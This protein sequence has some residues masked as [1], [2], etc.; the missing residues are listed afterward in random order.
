MQKNQPQLLKGFRDFLPEE[1][2]Q[3]DY[4]EKKIVG[5]FERFGFDPIETPALEYRETIMG[6]YGEEAD[7][8]VYSFKDRGERDVAL[9]Y[10]QTVPTAR[11]I[12]N[13]RDRLPFPFRRYQV[14]NVFRADKP[15]KGR[16]REFTQ[17]DIDIFGSTEPIA[18]AEVLAC[19]YFAYKNV[20]FSNV[21]LRV[22]DRRLLMATLE[23]FATDQVSVFSIIQS[24]DKL[25]KMSRDDVRG[26]LE[27]KGLGKD[28]ALEC[29]SAMDEAVVPPELQEILRLT[30]TL[31]VPEEALEFS[32]TTARGLDYYTG[33]IFEVIIPGYEVGSVGGGGRYDNLIKDLSGIDVPAVGMAFGFDRTVEAALN[34]NLITVSEGQRVLVSVF[35]ASLLPDSAKLALDLRNAGISA[36]LFTITEP[37]TKQLKYADRKAIRYVAIIGSDEKSKNVILLKDLKT[38]QQ[39][40]L[41]FAELV[42]AVQHPEA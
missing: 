1:K 8:L 22:N 19:T 28:R 34:Q 33:M 30:V 20:G 14:Q 12:A 23:P 31:G 10:D 32:P 5:V 9:R 17:C 36:E 4:I 11:V 37:L 16:Y 15:Q 26:E 40:A 2:R 42:K 24:L 39:T 3:R 7:K 29:L 35:D 38:G 41:A 21:I 13:Y 6:K 27:V 18:D 25:D